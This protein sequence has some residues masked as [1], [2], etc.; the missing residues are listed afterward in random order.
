MHTYTHAHTIIRIQTHTILYV[1]TIFLDTRQ[2]RYSHV[3]ARN[4]RYKES[5]PDHDRQKLLATSKDGYTH[6][7]STTPSSENQST[8]RDIH[9]AHEAMINDQMV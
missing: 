8:Q 5:P 4:A 7:Q 2:R 1:C 3:V 6:Q 9:S